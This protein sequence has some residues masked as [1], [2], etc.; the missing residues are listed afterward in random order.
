MRI[1]ML[2]T[3]LALSAAAFSQ[4]KKRQEVLNLEDGVAAQGYDV[5]AYFKQGK[6]V[7]GNAANTVSYQGVKYQFATAESQ[8]AFEANPSAF[9]PQYG[10]W[11]AYAMGN[12]CKKVEVDPKT[13]KIIDGKLFLFYNALLNNTLTTWN[14]DEANLKKKADSNWKKLSK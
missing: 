9:E 10:G 4:D 1:T 5:V 13:F 3:L 12:F 8:K 11:C 6:A 2:A 7:K 14:K